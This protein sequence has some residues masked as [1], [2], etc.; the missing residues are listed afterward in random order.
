MCPTPFH[1]NVCCITPSRAHRQ[2]PISATELQTVQE[3]ATS[4]TD[5]KGSDPD[6]L[7][8][9][10]ACTP[11]IFRILKPCPP[12]MLLPSVQKMLCLCRSGVCPLSRVVF[13]ISSFSQTFLCFY[14][15]LSQT[16]ITGLQQDSISL[17]LGLVH[18]LYE[19]CSL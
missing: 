5:T 19:V 3:K 14:L 7:R 12:T 6:R 18:G 9:S 11:I 2:G 8:I 10:S 15:T 1:E 16:L 4:L 17:T 13:S